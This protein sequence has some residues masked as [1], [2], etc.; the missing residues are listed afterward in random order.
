LTREQKESDFY[1]KPAERLERPDDQGDYAIWMQGAWKHQRL[2]SVEWTA[3]GKGLFY[4]CLEAEFFLLD[5]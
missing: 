4:I 1:L 3:T 2:A 5:P